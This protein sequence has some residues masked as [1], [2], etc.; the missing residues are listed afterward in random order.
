VRRGNVGRDPAAT[1]RHHL[2][3]LRRRLHAH[4]HVQDNR[5]VKVTSPGDVSVTHGYLCIKGRFGCTFV[6]PGDR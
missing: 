4:A 6:E 3:L 5:I 2:P 1:D